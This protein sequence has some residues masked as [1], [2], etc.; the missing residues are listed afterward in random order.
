MNIIAGE[1]K[2][3]ICVTHYYQTESWV[4]ECWI[5]K[6]IHNPSSMSWVYYRDTAGNAVETIPQIPDSAIKQI[7][8]IINDLKLYDSFFKDE[9]V[10]ANFK[11]KTK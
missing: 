2:T 7:V 11:F 8:K 3:S 9:F 1:W 4:I 5:I 10:S 6:V